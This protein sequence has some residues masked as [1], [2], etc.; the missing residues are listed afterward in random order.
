M[1]KIW[2]LAVVNRNFNTTEGLARLSDTA[3]Y[4]TVRVVRLVPFT[5]QLEYHCLS[6]TILKY[7]SLFLSSGSRN[8]SKGVPMT[9]ET[10]SP[11]WWPSFLTSFNRGR[12]AWTSRPPWITTDFSLAA[13]WQICALFFCL[14]F[15]P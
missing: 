8:L 12:G 3:S 7:D 4:R 2:H 14:I 9:G 11:I 10:C 5:Y 15:M 13:F 1:A 6:A